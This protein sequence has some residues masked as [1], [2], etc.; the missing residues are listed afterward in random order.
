MAA[1]GPLGYTLDFVMPAQVGI[2]C[3]GTAQHPEILASA[4]TTGVV[5]WSGSVKGETVKIGGVKGGA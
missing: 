1:S 5:G 3:D 4:G 2:S